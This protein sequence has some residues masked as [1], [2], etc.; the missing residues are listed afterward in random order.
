KH[1]QLA[2]ETEVQRHQHAIERYHEL[3]Q[4][5][6]QLRKTTLEVLEETSEVVRSNEAELHA[7]NKQQ[8]QFRLQ[9]EEELR[10]KLVD[11]ERK[12]QDESFAALPARAKEMLFDNAKLKDE[13]SLQ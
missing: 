4:E 8:L 2:V 9:L 12:Q 10:R 13:I 3:L 5:N 1:E 6:E 11:V 7:I